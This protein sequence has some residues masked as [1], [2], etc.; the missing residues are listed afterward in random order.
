YE[1]EPQS[2]AELFLQAFEKHNLKNALNYKKQGEWHAISSAEMLERIE[3][4]ALGLNA[5]GIHKGDRVA[6]LAANSPDWTLTDAGCQLSGIIDVPIYTT[7]TDSSVCYI[8]ND[9]GARVFFLDNQAAFDR[10]RAIF[11]E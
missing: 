9:S 11:S 2:L 8:I 6:I 7:L 10:L 4:I 3:N 5:L 1:N